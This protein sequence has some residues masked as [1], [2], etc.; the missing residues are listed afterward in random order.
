MNYTGTKLLET[1]RLI[2]RPFTVDDA[3][4]VFNNWAS[5]PEVTRYLTWPTHTNVE[6]SRG[7]M[8]YCVNGYSDPAS[9]QWGVVLKENGALVGNISVVNLKES[10][11]EAELGW[12]LGRNW[13]G[14]GIMPEAGREVIRF[15]FDEIGFNRITMKH[16]SRNPKSGRAIIKLGLR[17]EGTLRAAGKNNTGICDME[18]YGMLKG[19]SRK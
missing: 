18:I 3:E 2:L 17:H 14:M 6:M 10:T 11:M 9:F 19:D 8:Q 12:V 5:D 15:L 1:E 4:S 7:F 16:D 13:W